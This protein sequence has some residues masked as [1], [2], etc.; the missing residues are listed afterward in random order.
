MRL[1]TRTRRT[2]G[3]TLVACRLTNGADEPRVALVESTL[4]GPVR[5]PECYRTTAATLRVPVPANATVG[6]GFSTPAAPA[7]PAADLA[8][9]EMA[10]D[11]PTESA[12]LADLSDP[13][14]PRSA[15]VGA[16]PRAEN[17]EPTD[18]AAA[19]RRIER[20]EA[21]AAATTVPGAAAA[22]ADEGGLDVVR[23]LDA[24]VA[25]DRRRLTDLA[26]RARRLAGRAAAAD[27]RIGT[28]ERLS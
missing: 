11:G 22:L 16:E 1:S 19:E 2:D 12:V 15:V 25:A 3:V 17:A 9:T 13:R 23:D 20:L 10:A 4:D 8:G 28:L 27:P 6:A 7:S 24:R 18:F 21:V 26:D 14:P 5:V